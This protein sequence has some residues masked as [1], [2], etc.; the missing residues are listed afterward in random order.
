ML[1]KCANFA[2][3]GTAVTMWTDAAMPTATGVPT[4]IT[5]YGS[6]SRDRNSRCKDYTIEAQVGPSAQKL[7]VTFVTLK[8]QSVTL[9]PLKQFMM[10]N[11]CFQPT[12]GRRGVVV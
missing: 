12:K 1:N 9:V 6:Q 3:C 5:V 11:V 7:A 10:Q 2:G 8:N 4:N